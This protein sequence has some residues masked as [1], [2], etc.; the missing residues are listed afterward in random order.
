M[1]FELYQDKSGAWRWR[2]RATNGQLV[3]A[4]GQKFANK[5]NA[6]E[7]M[8]AV[9]RLVADSPDHKEVAQADPED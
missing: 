4:A 2:L 5:A 1:G 8:A 9:R 3:A 7:S 6:I